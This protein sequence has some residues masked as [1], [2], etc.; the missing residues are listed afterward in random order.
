MSHEAFDKEFAILRE[1]GE[2]VF[3]L[4]GS[5]LLVEVLPDEELKTKGGLVIA[6]DMNQIKGNSVN[7]HKLQ[8]GRVLMCGQG[9]WEET[10]GSEGTYT[11]LEVKPGAI[12]VLPQFST[13]FLSMFPGIQRPTGNRIGMVKMS[14]IL[15]YYPSSE[16]YQTAKQKLNE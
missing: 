9:Y 1:L 10:E 13:S 4:R 12:V 2:D 6:T 15:A 3:V 5:T 14:E 16:A 8:V 11:P 7:Q